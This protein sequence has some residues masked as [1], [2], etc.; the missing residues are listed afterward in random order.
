MSKYF[1]TGATGAVGSA[2][3]PLLLE[4]K[5]NLI[6]IIIRGDSDQKVQ[7]RFAEL[8]DFWEMT[9]AQA[10]DAHRRVIPLKGDTDE[11][12]FGLT[13]NEYAT[14]ANACTHIIHCAGVVRMNLPLDVARHHA[15]MATENVV[16]L[17]LASK[18][19]GQLQKIEFVSTVGVGGC[20][21]GTLPETWISEPREF[22]NTYEQ[23]KA[24]AE[25]YLKEKIQ[26]HQLPVTVHRPSMV[27]GDSKTGKIIH[28]QIFYHICEF[29]TGRRSFGMLPALG[30]VPLD[31]VPVD[32]VA[33]VLHWSSLRKECIGKILHICSG[34]NDAILLTDLKVLMRDKMLKKQIKTP[35][36]ISLPIS[37]FYMTFKV[38]GVFVSE[39]KR[40]AIK[41]IPV[42]LNY[43]KIYQSFGNQDTTTYL[44]KFDGPKI[45]DQKLYM[46]KV[47]NHYISKSS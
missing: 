25:D 3:I 38:V 6:W 9:E 32:Y 34:P 31:T 40:R 46:E 8:I 17:A 41:T 36:I 45:A 7:E 23:A 28:Y 15:L 14:I 1:V 22:H 20:L 18:A 30:K 26:L 12:N 16:K 43:L 47:I 35:K 29:L 37:W 4:D 13:E 2:L 44:Q 24:E 19:S 39:K 42:F 10:S 11:P 5:D 33:Q 21:R 27:V